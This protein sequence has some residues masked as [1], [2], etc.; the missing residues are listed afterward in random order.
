MSYTH[1]TTLIIILNMSYTHGGP[2][3]YYFM[4]SSSL[5]GHN[6][7]TIIVYCG[8]FLLFKRTDNHYSR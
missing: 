6:R 5:M 3:F 1:S 4:M 8:T 2:L 7:T